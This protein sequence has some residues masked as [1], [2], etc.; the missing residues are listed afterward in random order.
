MG[1][2]DLCRF[3]QKDTVFR[4]KSHGTKASH[5]GWPFSWRHIMC[6]LLEYLFLGVLIALHLWLNS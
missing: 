4:Y 5:S 1:Y 6:E 3:V 2:Q